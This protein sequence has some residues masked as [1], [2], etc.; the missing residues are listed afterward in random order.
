MAAHDITRLLASSRGGDRDAFDRLTPLVYGELRKIAVG[1]MRSQDPGHTLQP[2]ALLHEAWM[3]LAGSGAEY[4]DRAHFYTVAAAIMRHI[5][6][7]HARAA[8]TEKRGGECA[9]VQLQEARDAAVFRSDE[10]IALD[11]ALNALAKVDERKARVLELRYFGGLSVEETA[12][13]LGTSVATVGREA[14]FAEV[15]LRREL[16]AVK[17]I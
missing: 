10:L 3:R 13:A 5:L 14:R 8:G 12:Q 16:L 17:K 9:Q 6:V 7:D 11:D 1:Y 4:H 15:W 2:T